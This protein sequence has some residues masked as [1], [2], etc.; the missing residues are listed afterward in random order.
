MSELIAS[1]GT[2]GDKAAKVGSAMI[3][4][5]QASQPNKKGQ[6]KA[7][8]WLQSMKRPGGS[9]HLHFHNY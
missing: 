8:V 1:N 9:R 4:N 2:G 7:K 5:R 3:E 6:A